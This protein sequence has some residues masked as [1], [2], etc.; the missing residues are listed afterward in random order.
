MG[1]AVS[2]NTAKSIAKVSNNVSNSTTV[3]DAQVNAVQQQIDFD[4]CYLMMSGDINIESA[5]Q[6]VAKSKQ[7]V[8]AMQ[9]SHI[10]NT[11]AQQMMQQAKSQT[12][13]LGVGFAEANNYASQMTDATSNVLNQL[14]TVANQFNYI[15]QGFRC[16]GSTFIGKNFLLS[17]GSDANFFSEQVVKNQ[18]IS[19]IA[20]DI[21]QSITQKATATVSGMSAFLL[22]FVLLIA[23]CG[24]V[25]SK[26]LS[27]GSGK[28]IIGT[29]MVVGIGLLIA[30]GFIFA[31]P[32][33]FQKPNLCALAP[34]PF[35]PQTCTDPCINAT[36]QTIDVRVPVPFKFP[37]FDVQ[38]P[39]GVKEGS[40]VVGSL[41]GMVISKNA[42]D[43]PTLA[44]NMGMNAAAA[45]ALNQDWNTF[46]K[47]TNGAGGVCITIGTKQYSVY[48]LLSANM[49]PS[50]SSWGD[51]LAPM[52]VPT[53]EKENLYLIPRAYLNGPGTCGSDNTDG[54][55]CLGLAFTLTGLVNTVK[56]DDNTP[57]SRNFEY[58]TVCATKENSTITPLGNNARSIV[59][60]EDKTIY[61]VCPV[62]VKGKQAKN[63]DGKPFACG[64]AIKDISSLSSDDSDQYKPLLSSSITAKNWQDVS[65]V[66]SSDLSILM[67]ESTPQ[68]DVKGFL[69]SWGNGTT[70]PAGAKPGWLA[71]FVRQFYYM[72]LQIMSTCYWEPNDLIYADLKNVRDRNNKRVPNMDGFTWLTAAEASPP[73]MN[74][75]VVKDESSGELI[76]DA[77]GPYTFDPINV[78]QLTP[79]GS[80]LKD[81]AILGLGGA[82]DKVSISGMF[83]ICNDRTYQ[84]GQFSQRIGIYIAI[85]IVVIALIFVM[86]DHG[87]GRAHGASFEN[88][89]MVAAS[90]SKGDADGAE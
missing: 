70:S 74:R 75:F 36:K 21:T 42:S 88:P 63:S 83:G 26:P 35:M 24:Y 87:I 14:T 67:A 44:N 22:I 29:V 54:G 8:T 6:M 15:D 25:L 49:G 23:A 48:Q 62:D 89:E 31:W 53:D 34:M 13:F 47:T 10:Q 30:V 90:S 82:G 33:L 61:S 57:T 52:F 40:G 66:S 41:A 55:A 7:I 17:Q 46:W 60:N 78:Y 32:P 2:S 76:L 16:E 3:S 77:N 9:Q 45:R 72:K 5:S 64:C 50:A 58:P 37:I 85:G 86:L 51:A 68:E 65:K 84:F 43:D 59:P 12:G 80:T 27:S 20:N 69:G 39:A 73:S 18:Q 56:P 4:D 19:S 38:K 81:A 11:I 71:R 28:I 1:A 79:Q